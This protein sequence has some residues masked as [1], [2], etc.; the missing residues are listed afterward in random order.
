MYREWYVTVGARVRITLGRFFI[1]FNVVN[2]TGYNERIRF[3][4]V[5]SQWHTRKGAHPYVRVR[6]DSC[7]AVITWWTPCI[8]R[9][10]GVSRRASRFTELFINLLVYKKIRNYTYI[11][12]QVVF[13]D[14]S[15]QEKK[16][17]GVL[18]IGSIWIYI[19]LA[20]THFRRF[21]IK[22]IE[23]NSLIQVLYLNCK[24]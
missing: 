1:S 19:D 11:R 21:N 17:K 23:K 4:H 20:R 13:E 3:P 22:N 5:H 16:A 12:Y 7:F 18:D 9:L 10:R 6:S 2:L 8:F 14:I 15:T 24:T